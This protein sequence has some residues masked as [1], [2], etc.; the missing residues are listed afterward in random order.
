MTARTQF[1]HEKLEVYNLSLKFVAWL[2]DLLVEI[3][4]N[5]IPQLSDII[6]QMDRSGNSIVLNIA[7]GNGRRAT[8]QRARFFDDARGSA[9][10]PAACLDVAVA[11][12]A[13]E[14][15]RVSEGKA[16]LIRIVSML[17]KLVDRYDK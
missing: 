17:T 5:K 12:K 3:R 8:K 4:K 11:K 10:E 14:T 13:V 7:E 15:G 9:T 2:S 6:S 1:D 16:L